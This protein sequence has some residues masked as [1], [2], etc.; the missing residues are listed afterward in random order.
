MIHRSHFLVKKVHP[1]AASLTFGNADLGVSHYWILKWA[2]RSLLHT[3]GGGGAC[4]PQ[5]LNKGGHVKCQ[6]KACALL[7]LCLLLMYLCDVELQIWALCWSWECSPFGKKQ[8]AWT[9]YG[10]EGLANAWL[11]WLPCCMD[12][13]SRSGQHTPEEC[14]WKPGDQPVHVEH[15]QVSWPAPVWETPEIWKCHEAVSILSSILLVIPDAALWRTESREGFADPS[16][17]W[18]YTRGF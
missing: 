15:R 1:A 6:M 13:G 3:T 7:I 17:H 5:M 9:G 16:W 11:C 14:V 2:D 8:W 10:E 18:T 4:L 12:N